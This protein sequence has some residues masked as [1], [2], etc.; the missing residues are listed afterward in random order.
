MAPL[1]PESLFCKLD[2]APADEVFALMGD[3]AADT[4]PDKVSL[5]AGVYRDNEAKSWRLPAVKKAGYH[6]VPRMWKS[7]TYRRLNN[8]SSMTQLLTMNTFLSLAM[9]LST[10]WLGI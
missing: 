5:G 10:T 2:T 4:H 9:H 3:F 6:P 1:Q 7:L 8:Y